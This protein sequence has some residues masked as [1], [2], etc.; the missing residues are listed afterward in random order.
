M[1]IAFVGKGGSGKS[2]LAWLAMH[3]MALDGR[4]VFGIDADH[5]MDLAAQFGIFVDDTTPTMHRRFK[6]FVAHLGV[7]SIDSWSHLSKTLDTL[8]R[9]SLSPVDQFT[10]QVAIRTHGDTALAILGLGG[11]EVLT[12]G[13]CA[14]G[15]AAPLKFYLP[16]LDID[17]TTDVVVDSVAGTDMMNYGLLTGCDAIIGVAEDHPNSLRVI[18]NIRRLAVLANIPFF[19]VINKNNTS[20]ITSEVTTKDL[21]PS[22]IGYIPLDAGIKNSAFESVSSVAIDHIR[23]ALSTVRAQVKKVDNKKR[24]RAFEAIRR[25]EVPLPANVA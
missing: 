3:V 5:N 15:I 4:R 1:K 6:Q 13:K 9:F 10:E 21:M 17:D 12:S 22:M 8:P 16:L 2:S 18:E 25:K 23:K 7:T 14:H 11:H 19:I 20:V 24:V